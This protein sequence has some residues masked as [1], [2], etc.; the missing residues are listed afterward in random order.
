M[1]LFDDLQSKAAEMLRNNG[2]IGGTL[3]E[4]ISSL[5]PD[6]QDKITQYAEEHNISI[7]AAKEHLLGGQ[8]QE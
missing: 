6:L 2:D 3:G 4:D 1:G 8:N 7:E 5:S